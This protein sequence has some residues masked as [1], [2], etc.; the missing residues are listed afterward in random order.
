MQNL[1]NFDIKYFVIKRCGADWKLDNLRFPH[2]SLTIVLEGTALYNVDGKSI[3]LNAGQG[4]LIKPGS[5]R[6][7]ETKG[8][9]CAAIDLDLFAG[10]DLELKQVFQVNITENLYKLLRDFEY[11][12]IQH[13]KDDVQRCGA[14]LILILQS[15]TQEKQDY[16]AAGHVEKIKR[17]IMRHAAEPLDV[18]RI[19]EKVRLNPVYCGALFKKQEGISIKAYINRIRI[20]NA[21]AMLVGEKCSVG[22]AA[23]MSGFSDI[24]YF[25]NMF[26][27]QMGMPPS[28][29]RREGEMR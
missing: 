16:A 25:S 4:L 7:A 23:A 20:Q 2:H 18:K 21:A 5:H 9:T 3:E 15:A 29:Y 27:K 8:M 11:A 22:M 24:Y 26:K 1:L 12:W 17:Y 13:E 28:S 10:G 19:A 14:L 6:I